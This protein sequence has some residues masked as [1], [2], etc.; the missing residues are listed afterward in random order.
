MCR[1]SVEMLAG[2]MPSGGELLVVDQS[3]DELAV[4]LRDVSS[5]SGTAIRMFRLIPPSLVKAR[6]AGLRE[7]KGR[8]VIF[9]VDDIEP[10]PGLIEAHLAG[11]DDPTVGGVAGRVLQPGFGPKKPGDPE[12]VVDLSSPDAWKLT[13]LNS[14][15]A[16]EVQTSRGCNMSFRKSV[17]L[18]IDGFDHHFFPPMVFRD[19]TDACLCVRRAGHRIWYRPD[20]ALYHLGEASGGTRELKG[21]QGLVASELQMYTKL[22]RHYRCNLY[23]HCKHFRGASLWRNIVESYRHFVGVSRYPWRLVAKNVLYLTALLR[24]FQ[25]RYLC[26]ARGLSSLRPEEYMEVGTNPGA[27]GLPT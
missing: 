4:D 3:P 15:N 26:T 12:L 8:F 22:F 18:E 14:S 21:K 19:D 5:S 16:Q 9:V 11:F 10:L 2:M 20:A 1:Q 25:L 24:A 27:T 23:F 7:A 17:L 6:N 13:D